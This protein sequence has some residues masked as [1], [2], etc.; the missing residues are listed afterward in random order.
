MESGRLNNGEISGEHREFTRSDFQ[1]L[2][3]LARTMPIKRGAAFASSAGSTT[4]ERTVLTQT[5]LRTKS[6]EARRELLDRISLLS[7]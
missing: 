7:S 5:F 2:A 6:S 3:A 1:E 4:L